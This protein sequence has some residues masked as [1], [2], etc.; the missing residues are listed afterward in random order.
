MGNWRTVNLRGTLAPE[1]VDKATEFLTPDEMYRNFG[2]MSYGAG[3]AGLGRWAREV[4]N[5]DGNLAERDYGSDD[6]AEHLRG[7]VAVAP[8]LELKVHCG[9][10][11]EDSNC[12]ATVTVSNGEVSVGEPE[13]AKVAAV[14]GDAAL[15]RLIKFMNGGG[16]A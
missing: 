3:M 14:D 1:D 9:A 16:A 6:V 15:G 5:A 4:I 2:P 11:Y 8:S 12:I 13:V 7:L 10:D